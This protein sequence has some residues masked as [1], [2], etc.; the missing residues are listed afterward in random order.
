MIITASKL[1]MSDAERLDAIDDIDQS[2]LDKLG[3]LRQFNN[4]TSILALQR[5]KEENDVKVVKHLSLSS[6]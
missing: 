3:F 6:S 4:R 1:R 5:A 2:V